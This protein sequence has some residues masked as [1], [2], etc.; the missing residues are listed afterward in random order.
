[1]DMACDLGASGGISIKV[2]VEIERI[3]FSLGENSVCCTK[4]TDRFG[5]HFLVGGMS[6]LLRHLIVRKVLFGALLSLYFAI[7]LTF[8]I[9][10]AGLWRHIVRRRGIG[11]LEIRLSSSGS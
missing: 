10:L 4:T 1:M 2:A 6:T 11:W 3:G 8:L 7:L 9:S 5:L